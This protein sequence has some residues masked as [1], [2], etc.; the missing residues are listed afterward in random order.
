MGTEIKQQPRE[1]KRVNV[2]DAWRTQFFECKEIG[3]EPP[4][5][6]AGFWRKPKHGILK[7]KGD[8]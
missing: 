1:N 6:A 3:K 5:N 7:E 8:S 2:A 4:L